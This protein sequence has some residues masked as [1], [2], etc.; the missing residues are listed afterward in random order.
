MKARTNREQKIINRVTA[1]RARNNRLWMGLL[2]LALRSAPKEA[3]R[4]LRQINQ[5]DARIGKW[6]SRV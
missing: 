1:I 4:I 2:S 5:N 3:K 6:L